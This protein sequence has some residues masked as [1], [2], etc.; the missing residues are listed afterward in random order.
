[1]SHHY[2]VFNFFI[3]LLY[4]SMQSCQISD[5]SSL[6][7]TCY[8]QLTYAV[9]G[10]SMILIVTCFTL[11]FIRYSDDITPSFTCCGT[12]CPTITIANAVLKRIC[13]IFPSESSTFSETFILIWDFLISSSTI[14]FNFELYLHQ[15][16]F[17]F[18]FFFALSFLFIPK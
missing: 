14:V 15:P 16:L 5:F 11:C 13:I 4:F 6:F 7:S 1:M 9:L 3:T 18:T 10:L 17:F 8:N 12:Y 2:D